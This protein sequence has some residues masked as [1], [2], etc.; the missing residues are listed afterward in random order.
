VKKR[1]HCG[2]ELVGGFEVAEM[3]DAWQHDE[4]VCLRC[5]V[6]PPPSLLLEAGSVAVALRHE[7]S[8]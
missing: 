4:R 2:V 8:A 5:E 6:S 7:Q 1:P 3:T